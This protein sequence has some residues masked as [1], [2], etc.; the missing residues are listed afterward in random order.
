MDW[1]EYRSYH[2][3]KHGS[4]NVQQ[5][6][7]DYTKYKS[8]GKSLYRKDILANIPETRK[9]K[10]KSLKKLKYGEGRG[11]PTRGWAASSPQ[12]YSER[13]LLNAKC[14]NQAFLDPDNEKYPV[15]NAMRNTNKCEYVC[16]AIQS[17]KNRSCQYNQFD[18]ANKAQKL[19]EKECG[20]APKSPCRKRLA[21]GP[22]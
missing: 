6:S 22:Q 9:S 16:Q 18:I 14:G 1:N 17:A 20:W 2:K 15:M 19:G 21:P 11:S 7:T 8:K 5:L 10:I 3:Q 12:K 4:T 13:H